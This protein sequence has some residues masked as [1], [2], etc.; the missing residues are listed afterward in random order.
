MLRLGNGQVG[1]VDDA[2]VAGAGA[3][4]GRL[5]QGEGAGVAQ[6]HGAFRGG[7][8]HGRRAVVLLAEIEDVQ[9]VH[10]HAGVLVVVDG[11]G[12]PAQCPGVARCMLPQGDCDP[13][14]MA[15]GGPVL[16]HVAS[17]EHAEVMG[18]RHAAPG[19]GKS[20]RA[21]SDPLGAP[22]AAQAHAGAQVGGAETD[23]VVGVTGGDGGGGVSNGGV[24]CAPA[25]GDGF[26]MAQVLD[27]Q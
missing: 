19:R 22:G 12:I 10:H 24:A 21:A 20:L 1:A 18:G 26:P 25:V 7:H 27:A 11:D 2:V 8:D 16:V 4:G 13:P 5:D 9:R 3:L 6:L 15:A 14:E 17:N 23:H